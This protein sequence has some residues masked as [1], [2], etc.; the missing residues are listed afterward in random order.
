M[1]HNPIDDWAP[2]PLPPPPPP[3]LKN[4]ALVIGP[5]A[6]LLGTSIGSGEWLI[7]PAAV[8]R[9]GTA[10]LGIVTVSVFL[11][12]VFNI[13]LMRYTVSTGE[14]IFTGFMRLGKR[15]RMVGAV[16]IIF[17]FLHLGWPAFAA[18]SAAALFAVLNGRLP[19][20]A[21]AGS[22]TLYGYFTFALALAILL[23]GR[24][25]EKTL[26]RVSW[27]LMSVVF[28]FLIIV[29]VAFIPGSVWWSTIKGFA[30]VGTFPETV[31]WTLIG[32][33]AAYAGA[34][35]IANLMLSNWARDRGYGMGASVGAIGGAVGGGE[36]RLSPTGKMFPMDSESIG[37]WKQWM[38]YLQ[39]EQI[40]IWGLFCLI[41]MFLTVNMAVGTMPAGTD[42]AGLAAGAYQAEYLRASVGEFMWLLTLLNGFWILLSTQLVVMDGL[43][44]VTTDIMWTALPEVRRAAK[45]D[46][47]KVY[48]GLLAAFI[49]W[50]SF[51][52]TLAQPIVLVLI[53]ANVAGFILVF[54]AIHI[55]LVNR[56]LL[57]EPLRPSLIREALMVVVALF[58]G[59]FV[60]MNLWSL[61][62]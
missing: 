36:S 19:V 54:S 12:V 57:P 24:T 5:A 15:P 56:R 61:L 59:F 25:V 9:Y 42:I 28:L 2:A 47:R 45:D 31:D 10:L 41:G 35:G 21:D 3:S 55:I 44:R 33:F 11:Q 23:F 40:G 49:I 37:H 8:V 6:I 4:F 17:G 1:K 48:Y 46:V 13:E 14:P 27:T 16:Y 18:T 53:G 60:V 62:T 7:G 51:A 20:A 34:G 58:Y 30:F 22:V 43:V 32:A 38:T 26:E 52:L 29:N 50:G 39:A